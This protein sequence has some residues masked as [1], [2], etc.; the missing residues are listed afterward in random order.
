MT[1]GRLPTTA[2]AQGIH[3]LEHETQL[4]GR[5]NNCLVNR[6]V[7]GGARRLSAAGVG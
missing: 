6:T 4:L 5:D 2:H 3:T 1:L 7:H